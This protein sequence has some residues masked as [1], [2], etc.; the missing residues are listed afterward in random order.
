[1]TSENFNKTTAADMIEFWHL[2][3]I[4]NPILNMSAFEAQKIS[5]TMY[6]YW[7]NAGIEYDGLL[8]DFSA[9]DGT[10]ACP[11]NLKSGEDWHTILESKVNPLEKSDFLIP[12]A[13]VQ[14]TLKYFNRRFK[15]TTGKRRKRKANRRK[16]RI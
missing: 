8:E 6:W 9:F 15:E 13:L 12:H 2:N 7:V 1:M 14:S 16:K 10:T 4:A 3:F 5:D 11:I